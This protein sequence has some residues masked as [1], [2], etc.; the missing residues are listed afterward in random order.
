[1]TA[2]KV[3]HSSARLTLRHS[4]ILIGG[5]L[6]PG[7]A[8]WRIQRKWEAVIVFLVIHFMFI[9]GLYLGSAIYHFDPSNPIRSLMVK[10]AQ[11]ACGTVYFVSQWFAPQLESWP[12]G[13]LRRFAER[14]NF[15]RGDHV[16]VW[17][18]MGHTYTL[19]A[20]LLNLLMILRIY[21][22]LVMQ[23]FQEDSNSREV[24]DI[25][26]GHEYADT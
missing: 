25:Q 9:Y 7:F 5:W 12:D 10:G 8:H 14:F 11:M 19:T 23:T 3:T 18:D 20:G 22:Y 6:I 15:G 26:D 13:A 4:A 2:K 1:M 17:A 24:P 21:D 16:H